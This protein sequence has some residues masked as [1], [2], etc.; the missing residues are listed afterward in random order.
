HPA[1]PH[2]E[3]TGALHPRR[4]SGPGGM[5]ARAVSRG[6][7]AAAVVVLALFPLLDGSAY[8]QNMLVLTFL[9][10]IGATGWN[11]MGG[12]AGYISLGSSAFVGLGAYT[13][14][15]LAARDKIS[16]FLGCLA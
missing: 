13:T 9:L 2:R 11:I 10:A 15:I 1:R 5:S 3:A 8:Y 7:T 16:P 12:Y 4:A 6:L 14:G